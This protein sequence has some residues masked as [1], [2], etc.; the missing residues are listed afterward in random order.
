MWKV[1]LGYYIDRMTQNTLQRIFTQKQK[2]VTSHLGVMEN[3]FLGHYV[4][5]LT[6]NGWQ[7]ILAQKPNAVWKVISGHYVYIMTQMVGHGFGPKGPNPWQAVW[8]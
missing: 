2:S 3:I 1:I 4:Y 6:Q 5:I 8:V 7:R